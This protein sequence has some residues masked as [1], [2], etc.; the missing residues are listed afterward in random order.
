MYLDAMADF[1]RVFFLLADGARCDIL[2]DLFRA[3]D[4]PNL[5]RWIERGTNARAVSVFPSVTL[6]AYVPFVTGLF[7]G[8]ANIPGLRWFDRATY[9]SR[10][11]SV[12]KF[13]NYYGF[14][15]YLANRDL[16]AGVET[17]FERVRPSV[18]IY[19][20]VCR[21]AGLRTN[22]AYFIRVPIIAHFHRTGDWEPI[23]RRAD[24]YLDHAIKSRARA[25]FYAAMAIDE[26]SHIHGSDGKRAIDA[27]R[28]ID[29]RL[30]R[31]IRALKNAGT[32]DQTLFVLSADHG[33][34]PVTRHFDTEAFV[35]ARG[36]KTLYYPK[37]ARRYFRADAA[38][39]VAGNASGHIYLRHRTHGWSHP[40]SDGEVNAGEPGMISDLLA[41]EAIEFVITRAEG[42]GALI[43]SHRGLARAFE[44][45]GAF[46]YVVVDSD[47]FGFAPMPS[48]LSAEDALARTWATPYPDAIVQ[49]AQ[50]FR[51][52]RTGDI[53]LSSTLGHDLRA[54]FER[55]EMKSGHGS[56]REEHIRVPL[57]SNACFPAGPIRTADV[58]PTMLDLLGETPPDN[59]DG[60][61]RVVSP[62]QRSQRTT[63]A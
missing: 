37:A 6:A 56:L 36:L 28:A 17:L 48:R 54:R 44:G 20:G 8:T 34:R 14:G 52:P 53:V 45:G 42:G 50:L 3:G 7:P 10:R 4:M 12:A 49:T 2:D 31:I 11:F 27:Y 9:A 22:K 5:A 57:L 59:L 55:H 21:G 39:L 60:I 26:Y 30:G 18:N 15:S 16:R 25:I 1:D 43:R 13:R 33:H 23:D 62:Q 32:F 19:S 46:H 47:P 51:S 41:N 35:E 63:A 38:A 61:S 40:L 24:A 58:Y 29:A